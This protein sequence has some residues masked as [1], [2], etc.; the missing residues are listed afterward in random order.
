MS[1]RCVVLMLA[2]AAIATTSNV[3]AQEK[4]AS[5]HC[6][7]GPV[8][9]TYGGS[10]WGIYSCPDNTTVIFYSVAGTPAAEFF[11]MLYRD[12]E[13]MHLYGEGNGDKHAT[14]IAYEEL[15]KLDVQDVQ[16]LIDATKAITSTLS[17]AHEPAM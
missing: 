9:K 15:S 8:R 2:T 5:M 3:S 12:E 10:E 16:A 11:F 17:P 4:P 13:G 7:I 1:F 6:D 14:D